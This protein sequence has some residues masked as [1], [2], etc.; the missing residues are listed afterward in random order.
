MALLSHDAVL[1]QTLQCGS[2]RSGDVLLVFTKVKQSHIKKRLCYIGKV[3]IGVLVC[4][5]AEDDQGLVVFL[6]GFVQFVG[7]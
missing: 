6:F 4:Q 1:F 2:L 3:C 5:L 7:F